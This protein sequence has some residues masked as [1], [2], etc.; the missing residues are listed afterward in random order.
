MTLIVINL[1][2]PGGFN[3]LSDSRVSSDM[4][5]RISKVTD[6]LTKLFIVPFLFTSAK[7]GK[8]KVGN[9][10]MRKRYSGKFGFAFSGSTLAATTLHAMVSNVLL[11]MHDFNGTSKAP[12]FTTIAV[13]FLRCANLLNQETQVNPMRYEAAIFGYCPKSKT[14]RV[15][16]LKWLQTEEGSEI[17][18]QEIALK[19]GDVFA[20]GSGKAH[21]Y[22]LAEAGK[23]TKRSIF[24]LTI[25]AIQTN[26][27]KGT[28]GALQAMSIAKA[29]QEYHA[30]LQKSVNNPLEVEI[31]VAGIRASAL[32]QIDGYTLGRIAIG[33]GLRS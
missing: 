3:A 20:F 15:F 14:P 9:D 32:Q 21:F 10:G 31:F 7:K 25:E 13:V 12:Q 11:N 18:M 28:G 22:R 26:P 1:T 17:G 23:K 6:S 2:D 29:K 4:G 8:H 16:F 5:D 30:V 27:D 19:T 24:D 33:A